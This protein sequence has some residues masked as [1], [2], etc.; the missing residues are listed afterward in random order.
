M[1]IAVSRLVSESIA[2]ELPRRG[3][4]ADVIALSR[5]VNVRGTY[6]DEADTIALQGLAAHVLDAEKISLHIGGTAIATASMSLAGVKADLRFPRDDA[7]P[8]AMTVAANELST[9]KLGV[10]A[11]AFR[12]DADGVQAAGAHVKSDAGGLVIVADALV[13]MNLRVTLGSLSIAVE[14]AALKAVRVVSPASGDL[15]LVCTA[16][17]LEGITVNV[18]S[19]DVTVSKLSLGEGLSWAGGAIRAASAAIAAATVAL[20]D[21]GASA[22][23][24]SSGGSAPPIDWSFLDGLGAEIDIEV[25]VDAKIPFI[26][27]LAKKQ[28]FHVTVI[29]GAID[30]KKFEHDLGFLEDAVLDF[31]LEADRLILEKDIPLIPFDNETL[32]FWPLDANE[33]ALAASHRIRLSTLTRAQIPPPKPKKKKDDGKASGFEIVQVDVDPIRIGLRLDGAHVVSPAPGISISLGQGGASEPAIEEL[34][35]AGGVHYA[36]KKDPILGEVK[37][38]ARGV[39]LGAVTAPVGAGLT[40][41]G[42]RIREIGEA[43]VTLAGLQPT[44]ASVSFADADLRGLVVRLG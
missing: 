6:A 41:E 18:G 33:R 27:D 3:G 35:I 2:I 25:R 17:E 40:L 32:V 30:Y 36:P 39:L 22:S 16:A 34:R 26:K 15:E 21:F 31:E 4:D 20:R 29:E 7:K 14:R 37:A 1:R 38:S 19:V 11:P 12:V 8:F 10:A 5:G 28:H 42:A 24:A 44:S 9:A 43:T 13:A 23:A